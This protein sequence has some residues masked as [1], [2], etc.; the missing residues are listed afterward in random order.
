MEDGAT[1]ILESSWALNTLFEGSGPFSMEQKAEPMEDGLR[2]M[3][4]L[5]KLYTK[6]P[7]LGKQAEWLSMMERR[8]VRRI[9]ASVDRECRQQHVP[10]GLARAGRH[11][12]EIL[13]AMYQSARQGG[14]V[15]SRMD[16]GNRTCTCEVGPKG[17]TSFCI[18]LEERR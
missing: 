10:F 13:E 3:E 8:N 17:L 7:A 18:I 5:G 11:G 2:L 4:D 14:P 16:A 6:T 1:I 12:D 15:F 9:E